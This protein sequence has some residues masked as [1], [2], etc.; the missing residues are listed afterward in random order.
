MSRFAL[1]AAL[2]TTV[3]L[4]VGCLADAADSEGDE[5]ETLESAVSTRPGVNGGA[6]YASDYNCKLRTEGGNRIAHKDGSL[7]WGVDKDVEVLDG[8]GAVLGMS[9]SST[10][11]FN[12]GQKRTFGGAD[13]V[14]AMTTSNHSAGW[15]PLDHVKSADVLED[16]V[17]HVTAHRSGLAKMACYEIK[18]SMDDTLAAKKVVYDAESAPGP[19]GEAAG[20]YLPRVR[21]NGKRSANLVFNVPG[22]ALGGPAIDH[23]PAGTK[24]QRLDVPTDGGRPSIDA[25]LWEQDGQGRFRKPAGELKFVYGYVLSATGQVRTGWMAYEA[26]KKSNACP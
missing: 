23:F 15:F 12:Y 7:D 14:F 9:H 8:N 5:T 3:A 22:S 6:C 24:F 20:D 21:V 16:R 13:Y 26:L 10:L 25:D 17:G 11:K 19:S 18:N 4:Q 1:T 2:L